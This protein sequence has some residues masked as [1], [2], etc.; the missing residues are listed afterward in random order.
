MKTQTQIQRMFWFTCIWAI[1]VSNKSINF[2]EY[3][4]H[5][6]PFLCLHGSFHPPESGAANEL[7]V[8][9]LCLGIFWIVYLLSK[10]LRFDSVEVRFHGAYQ[11]VAIPT[12]NPFK[13]L[14]F[15]V[16]SGRWRCLHFLCRFVLPLNFNAC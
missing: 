11:V 5:L 9:R 8:W 14:L 1:T 4:A 16:A 12:N 7:S 13:L 15:A 3:F 6:Y 10:W 2:S